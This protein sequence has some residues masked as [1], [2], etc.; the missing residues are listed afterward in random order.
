MVTPR[1]NLT[2]RVLAALDASPSRIPLLVGGCGS[3]RTTLVQQIKERLART[4]ALYID[5]ERCAA[6]P[7]R[8]LKA[9]VVSSPFPVTEPAPAGERAASRATPGFLTRA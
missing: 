9:V 2:R 6:T 4:G 3:G 1:T 5:A 7:E 8:F